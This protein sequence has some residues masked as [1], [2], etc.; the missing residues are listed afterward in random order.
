LASA[1]LPHLSGLARLTRL[2]ASSRVQVAAV[3]AS[4]L[5]LV[6]PKVFGSIPMA[7]AAFVLGHELMHLALD[8]HGREGSAHPLLVNFAHDY[9][10]NDML[11]D[12]LERDPPLDGL[13]MLGAREKSLEQLVVELSQSGSDSGEMQCWS[14]GQLPQPKQQPRSSL[15]RALEEAGLVEP[16]EPE[17]EI[18]KPD[19]DL[20]RGDVL[21]PT[22]EDEFEPEL[23]PNLRKRLQEEV[24]KA[25][26]KA[27][28]LAE[29]KAKMDAAGMPSDQQ[30]P[31]RGEAMMRALRDAYQVP[32]ELALQRW[33]DAV[34]PGE[35]TY[36]RPSRRGGD[37]SD[38]VLPGRRREGWTLHIVLDTS[39]SMIDVLPKALGAIAA[40]CDAS[41]VAD[42]HVVQCDI[43]VTS[44]RWVEPQE[45]AEFK[46]A[47]FGYSDMSPGMLHLA[48]DPEVTAV[49]VLTDGYIDYPQQTPPYRVLWGLLGTYVDTNFN[50]PY[51]QVVRMNI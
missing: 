51:G 9:I 31:Q 41:G 17:P 4:G 22:R 46:I 38:V 21:P 27:A 11:R 40:F 5:M 39:G 18:A 10:I 45:L 42:V 35:R 19:P 6:N 32:W 28:S 20:F 12:E 23:P 50:P 43:E 24:R 2:K 33:M 49:L 16:P 26:A 48:D 44:D 1:S 3:A 15:S 47:G 13:D 34:A 37:R 36:A 7:D 29:L 14:V 8:T 30:E 25:A